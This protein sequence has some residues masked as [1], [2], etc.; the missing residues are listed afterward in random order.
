MI[1]TLTKVGLTTEVRPCDKTSLLIFI[2]AASEELLQAQVYRARLQDWLYGV[3]VTSPGKDMKKCFEEEPI[4]DAERLRVVYLMITKPKSEGGAGIGPNTK[5]WKNVVSLF[6]LHDVEFNRSL[7]MRD[8]TKKLFLEAQDIED[9]RLRFGEQIAFYFAFMQSYFRFLVFPAVFGTSVWLLFGNLHYVYGLGISIWSMVFFEYWKRKQEDLAVQWGVRGVSRIQNPR[10]QF[11][12]EREMQD[13][14]TGEVVRYFPPLKRF[15]R[16]LWQIPFALASTL[17]LGGLYLVCFA[18]EIFIKEVYPGPWK[19]W[20]A[21]LPTI[22]LSVLLPVISAYLTNF[23]ELLTDHENYE[24]VDAHKAA[25]VQKIFVLNFITSYI[26]LILTSFVYVPF[27]RLLVP[28][29]D[30]FQ[31]A[32]GDGEAVSAKVYQ[33]DHDRLSNQVI[34]FTA[35][36]QVVNFATEL[37]L[38]WA[39]QRAARFYQ[40]IKN[41][42]AVKSGKGGFKPNDAPEEHEFLTRVRHEAELDDY[43]VTVDYREMVVQFGRLRKGDR[44][45]ISPTTFGRLANG[46]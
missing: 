41:E 7:L 4:T 11:Y 34:Y 9:I 24:T 45:H 37:I 25:K 43:D 27:G 33:M 2:K 46:S 18:L 3:R 31:A 13:P 22:I 36:A 6:P 39:K 23:A 32:S 16:Q 20:L 17:A 12:F 29:L 35:T 5:R 8:W 40:D 28:Y 42:R 26:P 21:F 44:G 14:I 15:A 30:I 1:E 19:Q 10:P 38:P